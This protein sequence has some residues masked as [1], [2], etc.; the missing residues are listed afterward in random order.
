[1]LRCPELIPAVHRLSSALAAAYRHLP[2]PTH[3][4]TQTPAASTP[5]V[6]HTCACHFVPLPPATA[7]TPARVRSSPHLTRLCLAGAWAPSPQLPTAKKTT[8]SSFPFI[9]MT[10]HPRTR[11]IGHPCME[12]R[13]SKR[14]RKASPAI[15]SSS[16]ANQNES[17]LDEAGQE[18]IEIVHASQRDIL[19]K[20]GKVIRLFHLN[21]KK[22]G[23]S[24]RRVPFAVW[25]YGRFPPQVISSVVNH[26]FDDPVADS[27]LRICLKA[28]RLGLG[29]HFIHL[30]L[31][32]G[33]IASSQSFLD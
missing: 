4:T 5:A 29:N 19:L 28:C 11:R 1:M 10:I 17:D 15:A 14:T 7:G 16:A 12:P 25:A 2:S 20:W 18:L 6:S 32:F 21:A 23:S 13:R 8:S 27:R 33:K 22:P 31:F 26:I 3:I 30:L 24:L 9:F